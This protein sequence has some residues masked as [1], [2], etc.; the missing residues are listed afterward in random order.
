MFTLQT[1]VIKKTVGKIYFSEGAGCSP[2]SFPLTLPYNFNLT[3]F[4]PGIS[5]ESQYDIKS[6]ITL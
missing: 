5:I 1:K 4:M 3:I 2:S 6:M